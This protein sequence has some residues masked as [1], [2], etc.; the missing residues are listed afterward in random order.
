MKKHS[1]VLLLTV[2]SALILFLGVMCCSAA[3]EPQITDN[4][5][6][7]SAAKTA[8]SEPEI[9][10]SADGF[11]VTVRRKIQLSA[12]VSGVDTQ[13]KITWESSD[14]KVA[15]VSSKGV[16]TGISVGRA[17][18]TAKAKVNG[19]ILSAIY[20]VNVV[21]NSNVIRNLLENRQILSYQYSYVDDYYYTNDKDNWQ[22]NLGFARIYDLVA[23]YIALEYDY[24]RVF[25]NY[26][27]KDFMI[28]LWKG[29]Y[30]YLFYGG[31]IG[32]YSRTPNG[33]TDGILT[34]YGKAYEEYWP[35][36]EMSLYHQNIL[37]KYERE[38][39]RDYDKY[40]WCTGFK[41]G[42]LRVVEPADELRIVARLTL[43]DNEMADKFAQGLTDCGFKSVSSKDKIGLD[44][45][46]HEGQDVYLVWQNI[47]EAEN[48]MPIKVGI[49][50][51]I[52]FNFLAL[53]MAGLIS[54]GLG[55]L[56][57]LIIL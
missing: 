45:Y 1:K 15:I 28:Q 29:Q 51:M 42:H 18:I 27:N 57:F 41:S 54:S 46:Y 5:Y 33:K 3:S 6:P 31:E 12:K 10:I 19:K 50:A 40:W 20:P 9:V 8:A 23:P 34:F 56:I 43:R 44:Q 36:M 38:F 22:E 25:F 30:G 13:P 48:T 16:V 35:Y 21:K 32:V 24:T 47:S 11:N 17:V 26:D 14:N 4:R 52:F 2:I 7:F 49:V 53:F 55:W 37:G 39:T